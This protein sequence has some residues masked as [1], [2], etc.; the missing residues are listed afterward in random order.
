[1]SLF[2]H[3]DWCLQSIVVPGSRLLTWALFTSSRAGWLIRRA[4]DLIIAADHGEGRKAPD[5]SAAARAQ[6]ISTKS[7]GPVVYMNTGVHRHEYAE[8][9]YSTV[10]R[11]HHMLHPLPLTSLAY[12]LAQKLN[13]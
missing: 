1:M 5:S 9:D 3:A 4:F 13:M 7:P 12:L 10:A 6:R 8:I 2:A 11:S